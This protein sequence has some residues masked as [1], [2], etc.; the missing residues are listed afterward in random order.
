[1]K[2]NESNADRII[3]VVLGIALLVVG[4]GGFIGGSL[5][6]VFKIVGALSLFTGAVGFCP[7]YALLKFKT[8]KSK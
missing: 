5:G 2:I 1:M 8:K 7:V 4:F 3:R 6:L